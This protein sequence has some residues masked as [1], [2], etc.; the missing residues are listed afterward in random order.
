M[1]AFWNLL[2]CSLALGTGAVWAADARTSVAVDRNG[3][4]D[5]RAYYNGSRDG[6]ARTKASRAAPVRRSLPSTSV[7]FSMT[8]G[9]FIFKANR[10]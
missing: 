3:R 5:A 9:Q 2:A 1:K 6:L 4:P 8:G 7:Q 10:L